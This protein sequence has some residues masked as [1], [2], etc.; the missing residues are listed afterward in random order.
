[1]GKVGVITTKLHVPAMDCASEE[2]EIRRA[3]EGVPG[4]ESLRSFPALFL[5]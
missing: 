1:M 4:I 2:A 5:Q 3:L